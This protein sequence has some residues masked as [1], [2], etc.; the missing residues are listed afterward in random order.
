MA[1]ASRAAGP[2]EPH[3]RGRFFSASITFE[4][5]LWTWTSCLGYTWLPV[6]RWSSTST[7]SRINSANDLCTFCIFGWINV[8]ALKCF[9]SSIRLR[10]EPVKPSM[11]TYHGS[12]AKI[13]ASGMCSFSFE[14]E[15]TDK[16]QYED[17]LLL[18]WK[19]LLDI[20][21]HPSHALI[22]LV[23]SMDTGADF[24]EGM[25]LHTYIHTYIHTGV[26]FALIKRSSSL[27]DQGCLWASCP[28]DSDVDQNA[29]R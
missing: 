2:A 22:F 13:E 7:G 10:Q 25:L 8:R 20:S 16:A 3:S 15:L 1:C 5:A 9:L 29:V 24:G 28:A 23:S 27:T 11:G 26:I 19:L 17:N 6:L 14:F 12:C 21:P 4:S 18:K